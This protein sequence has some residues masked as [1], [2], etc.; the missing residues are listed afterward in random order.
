MTRYLSKS[1]FTLAVS[2]PTKLAYVD[3]PHYVDNSKEDEFIQMLSEGGFQVGELA[4]MMFPGGVEISGPNLEEQADRTRALLTQSACTLF[5]A[6]FINDG[7]LARVDILRKN[8]NELEL[9]EVKAKSF[10]SN[11]GDPE[12][13]WRTSNGAKIRS[14]YL[15]YLQDIAFQAMVVSAAYPTLAVKPFLMLP[16]K[17][18][19]ASVQGMSEM[20]R[21]RR[22]RH[23][24]GS[25]RSRAE[26]NDGVTKEKIGSPLLRQVNVSSF[27]QQILTEP[28]ATPG[29]TGNFRSLSREWASAFASK[30]RIDPVI[31][32]QCR[33]C[34]FRTN[35]PSLR[36]RSGFHECWGT[37][38][39]RVHASAEL[40]RPIV[41]LYSPMSGQIE[42]LIHSGK[43]T[44]AD[45]QS[46]DLPLNVK[47]GRLTRARR[48]QM[49]VFGVGT[50]EQYYFDADQW[51]V[52]QSGFTWPLNFIDFEGARPA[53]PSQKGSTPYEQLAFQF[54]HHVM[55]RDWSVRHANDFIMLDPDED[56]NVPFVRALQAALSAP[57]VKNGTVFMWHHYERDV[58]VSL[59]RQL[60]AQ[61]D[62]KRQPDDINQL[63]EFLDARSAA[64]GPLSMVDMRV[65]AE[66]LF[67]HPN[68]Q[69]RSSIKV[70]LP[71]VLETSVW[72]KDRYSRPVYGSVGG[73]PSRNFPLDGEDGMI[74]WRKAKENV[75]NPYQMLPPVF[76]DLKIGWEDED[77][78]EDAT[79]IVDG[80]AAATA[81]FRMRFSDVPA[82]EREATRKAMLRYCELDTLAMVMI[83]ESWREWSMFGG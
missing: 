45:L 55:E 68:T 59:K 70:V 74:W 64:K 48:Q 4:K 27:V 14:V 53:L 62:F 43:L 69:G 80:G 50:N 58:L 11:Q 13:A 3:N 31:G 35:N 56:P 28:L 29:G 25:I 52:A 10:S 32:Q 61:R 8:G 24:D 75:V 72:L 46:E 12:N 7:L 54:S 30:R 38:L 81:Y 18:L 5:E 20:F 83:F 66:Q 77:K 40:G 21:I 34:Q 79:A 22:I 36:M 71:A 17:S 16:D 78:S 26:P 65:F 1:H 44:F 42:K 33:K 19:A 82:V 49:Q 67:F 6:T 51:R 39:Q 9:I 23:R 57:E 47:G 41:D 37:A 60:T 63:L 76:S 15:K 2:C 73:I